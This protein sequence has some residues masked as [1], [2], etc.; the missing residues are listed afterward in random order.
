MGGHQVDPIVSS[1]SKSTAFRPSP[2]TITSLRAWPALT[3]TYRAKCQRMREGPGPPTGDRRRSC[4]A[5]FGR[6]ST[7]HV[8]YVEGF[9]VASPLCAKLRPKRKTSP[10]RLG[11][12]ARGCVWLAFAHA[13][14]RDRPAAATS[15]SAGVSRADLL[16]ADGRQRQFAPEGNRPVKRS[17]HPRKRQPDGPTD[18]SRGHC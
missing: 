12:R 1:L 8:W 18:R 15:A 4:C 13:E 5:V 7:M 9:S 2:H 3:G 17:R 14:Q 11:S 16:T 6:P 10:Y